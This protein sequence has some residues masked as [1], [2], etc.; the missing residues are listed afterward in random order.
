MLA[1]APM[2]WSIQAM[3]NT[4]LIHKRFNGPPNS[5]H[6]GYVAGLIAD[7]IGG[8]SEV[9]LRKPPPLETPLTVVR[10]GDSVEIQDG[11]G[12]T[13]ASGAPAEF[14]LEIPDLPTPNAIEDAQTRST[15]LVPGAPFPTCFACGHGRDHGDGLRIFAGPVEGTDLVAARWTP[16][17]TLAD[18]AETVANRFLWAALDC[19]SYGALDTKPEKLPALLGRMTGTVL[20]SVYANEHT[21]IIAWPLARDGRKLHSASALFSESGLLCAYA[22]MVWITL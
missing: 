14:E 6:G 11:E 5:A 20:Q 7:L 13:Q 19:P 16:D 22:K 12:V 18:S 15:R 9:T 1:S 10:N 3:S 8:T 4:V 21:S 2:L 17:P